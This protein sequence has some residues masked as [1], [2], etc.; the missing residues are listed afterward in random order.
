MNRISASISAV[1]L[2]GLTVS[3]FA[4]ADQPLRLSVRVFQIPAEQS[5]E[6]ERSDGRG[7]VYTLRAS[8]DIAAL[9]PRGTVFVPT[10]LAG[11]AS[12][13][14]V[15]R[16]IGESVVFGCADLRAGQVRIRELKSLDVRLDAAHPSEET[17][18]EEGRRAGR[19]DDYELRVERL[20]ANPEKPLIRL[21]FFAG[22]SAQ[23]GRLGVGMSSDVISAVAEVPD[24]KLLLIG[25]PGEKAVYVL[26]VC[27]QPR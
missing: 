27:A 12:E 16:T 7:G 8:G 18:F 3:A 13:S 21:R 10:E 25:A 20:A 24:S 4:G 19:T 14:A 17:R 9:F 22:W 15:G 6:V 2:A 23:S 26:A 1:L 11:N 5:F